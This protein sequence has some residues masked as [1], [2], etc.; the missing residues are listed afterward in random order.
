[1]GFGYLKGYELASPTLQ[2]RYRLTFDSFQSFADPDVSDS[3]LTS[4]RMASDACMG[5][6]RLKGYELGSQTLAKTLSSNV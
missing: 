5:F 2:K 1:M 6:G 3:H 4:V